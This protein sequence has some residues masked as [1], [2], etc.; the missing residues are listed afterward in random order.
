MEERSTYFLYRGLVSRTITDATHDE[1]VEAAKKEHKEHGK[2]HDIELY[3][4]TSRGA[5]A[6]LKWP[7]D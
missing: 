6:V 3:K 4:K 1:A 5:V 2:N 7:A